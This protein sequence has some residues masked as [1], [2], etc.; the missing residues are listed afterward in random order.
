MLGWKGGVLVAAVF[1]LSGCGDD[2]RRPGGVDSGG[3]DAS[4]RDTGGP[5]VP[6]A[7][8][9]GD[10]D[11]DDG[12]ACT[13]DRCSV[14]GFCAH[15]PLDE[16]CG[17]GELC[18]LTEGCTSGCTTNADCDD[19]DFCDG[20]EEC[21]A[22]DCFEG[23]PADCD[24]GNSCTI[25][26]CDP[27]VGAGGGCRY[28]TAEGCDAGVGPPRDGGTPPVPFDP[29]MHYEGTFAVA[30]SPSLGCPGSSYA[31]GEVTFSVVGGDLQVRADRFL[32]TQSPRPDGPD[33]DVSS[34]SDAACRPV[35]LRGTFENSNVLSARW[36]AT[37]SGTCGSQTRDIVGE[38][39]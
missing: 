30:P 9:D 24:D 20:E 28:E 10:E 4:S 23:D 3:V 15:T 34:S 17:E 7:D 12:H 32:M 1:C 21:I 13:V 16:R 19:G 6:P 11:C 18:T 26:M 36:T 39:R 29:T 14:G 2:D 31:F 5:D 35:R 38:R 8:C 37:C 27:A 33:F 22:G 25:D